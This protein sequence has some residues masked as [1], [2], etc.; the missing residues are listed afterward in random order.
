MWLTVPVWLPVGGLLSLPWWGPRALPDALRWLAGHRTAA[1][2]GPTR[3]RLSLRP[4]SLALVLGLSF[5]P[6]VGRALAAGKRAFVRAAL[7]TVGAAVSYFGWH[8]VFEEVAPSSIVGAA[9]SLKWS[10]VVAGLVVLFPASYK[11]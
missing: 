7:F 10:I 4:G 3:C 5:A 9:S 6:M 11:K 2:R 8:A 1:A